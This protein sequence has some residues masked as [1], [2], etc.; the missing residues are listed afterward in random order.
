MLAAELHGRPRNLIALLE[1]LC[2]GDGGIDSAAHADQYSFFQMFKPPVLFR[3]A[4][5][6]APVARM[7]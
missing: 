5:L 7:L 4:V 2:G 3:L 6:A 1:Q